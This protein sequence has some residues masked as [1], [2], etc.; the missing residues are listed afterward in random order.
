MKET[1]QG[2]KPHDTSLGL[3]PIR[4]AVSVEA[5]RH[6]YMVFS[7]NSDLGRFTDLVEV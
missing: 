2:V 7:N 6:L 4:P 1:L 5:F 3:S